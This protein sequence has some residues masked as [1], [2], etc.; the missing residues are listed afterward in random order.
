MP[1]EALQLLAFS[2]EKKR[3]KAGDPLFEASE[4]ADAGYFVLSGAITLGAA[5][6]AGRARQVEAGGLIGETALLAEVARSF[7]A[8]AAVNAV[9]L[10]VPR[11]VFRRVLLEF[12]A[13]AVKIRSAYAART[14][15]LVAD[16]DVSRARSLD[17]VARPRNEKRRAV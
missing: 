11:E 6:G 17:A 8:R 12:P 3:L 1:R 16:L 5:D 13:A 10:R 4:R 7:S 15:K 2:S 14:R 9:V